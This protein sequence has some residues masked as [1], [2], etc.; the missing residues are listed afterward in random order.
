MANP[1]HTMAVRDD[2]V[3]VRKFMA[4][5]ATIS[6]RRLDHA[7]R[8]VSVG[9]NFKMERVNTLLATTQMVQLKAFRNRAYVLAIDPPVQQSNAAVN[10]SYRIAV[11]A[12]VSV[13]SALP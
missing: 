8:V 7:T 9:Y 3:V 6:P 13:S 5:I 4:S 10:A 11:A 2:D 1:A 12:F